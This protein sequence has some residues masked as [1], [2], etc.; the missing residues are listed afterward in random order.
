MATLRGT[1]DNPPLTGL[2]PRPEP[3]GHQIRTC[4]SIYIGKHRPA[5]KDVAED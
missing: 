2:Q 1:D 5:S 3:V 4:P